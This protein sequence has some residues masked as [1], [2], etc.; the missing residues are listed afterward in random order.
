MSI[1]YFCDNCDCQIKNRVTEGISMDNRLKNID[2]PVGENILLSISQREDT[3]DVCYG[4]VFTALE[5]WLTDI[6]PEPKEGDE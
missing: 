3:H 2:I 4:C 1:K 5:R 6:A